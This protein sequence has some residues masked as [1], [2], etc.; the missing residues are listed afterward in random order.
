MTRR[1]EVLGVMDE[2]GGIAR[3]V[4]TGWKVSPYLRGKL[5]IVTAQK[6][7]GDT[8]GAESLNL[9]KA[10]ARLAS[11]LLG[12]HTPV[13]E[14]VAVQVLRKLDAAGWGA[15]FSFQ[16]GEDE[17][18]LHREGHVSVRAYGN[19]PGDALKRAY[20]DVRRGAG[21]SIREEAP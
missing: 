18:W 16:G 10:S 6:G 1:A 19:H 17:V 14:D 3:L 20:A 21:R 9:A 15:T 11:D 5:W 7:R 4:R 2:L 13:V 8:F 12:G